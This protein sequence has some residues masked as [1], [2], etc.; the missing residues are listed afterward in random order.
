[1]R[2][3]P[4][5]LMT[6]LM[7]ASSTGVWAQNLSMEEKLAAIRKSLVATALEGPTKVTSTQWIDAQGVLRESSSFR[8]DVEVRGVRVLGY[9]TDSEGE[10]SAKLQWQ[11]LYGKGSAKGTSEV[12]KAE[13]ACKPMNGNRLQHLLGLQWNA[14]GRFS[15]EEQNLVEEFRGHWLKQLTSTGTTAALWSITPKPRTEGRS[16]YENALLGAGVDDLPWLLDLTVVAVPRSDQSNAGWTN[17]GE[18]PPVLA[19]EAARSSPRINWAFNM[20]AM[21]RIELQ[22]RLIARN[23]TKPIMVLS[24]PMTLMAQDGNWGISQLSNSSRAQVLQL[25]ENNAI[26]LFKTLVCQTVVGEV[27]QASGKQFRINLGAASGV[28]VGDT[29]VLANAAKLPQRALEPGNAAE[30]VM[31]KVQYVTA[32]Y[33]QLTPT[34]GPAQNVQTRWAAWSAEDAR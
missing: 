8:S 14:S 18:R 23:Q 1:M 16:G 21:V 10:A 28:R 11:E 3:L 17:A 26:E 22:M 19:E 31:A 25:A 30:T 7:A 20:P 15:S 24:T 6:L 33:A 5:L 2:H 32:H 12:K 29:W 4:T 34:A 13:P 9:T 27:T